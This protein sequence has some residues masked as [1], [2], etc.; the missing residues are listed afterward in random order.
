MPKEATPPRK[1]PPHSD[2]ASDYVNREP[3]NTF[4]HPTSYNPFHATQHRPLKPVTVPE[5]VGH[6]RR[7]THGASG[8]HFEPV[9][10]DD[11]EQL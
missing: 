8:K 1:T 5:I 3:L 7:N 9:L 4:K 10:F 11:C 6:V 2:A